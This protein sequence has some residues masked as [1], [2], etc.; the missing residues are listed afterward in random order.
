[1]RQKVFLFLFISI[2]ALAVSA[3]PAKRERHILTLADGT[4]VEA[5]SMGDELLHFYKTEDGRCL[6]RDSLGIAHFIGSDELQSRWKAKAERRQAARAARMKKAPGSKE[7]EEIRPMI[8]SKTGLVVLVEFPD[9]KFLFDE[10]EFNS[11]FNERGYSGGNNAGSVRDYYNDV[12][13]GLFDFTFDVIGPITMSQPLSYYGANNANGDDKGPGQMVIEALGMIDDEVDF[14]K[15]DWDEDGKVEQIFF[16]HA[17]YDEA[18]SG[19][20]TDI[21]SHA[22]TL[23][24]AKEYGDG[25]GPVTVDGVLA[26]RYATSSELRGREG[27]YL[28]GIGTACHEFAH[29]FGLPDFYDT[30]SGWNFGM[31]A[32]D[33]MDYGCYNGNGGTPCGFTSYE[34]MVCGWLKPIELTDALVVRNMPAITSEPVAYIL[35]N[36]GKEDE[37]YLLEN[38]QL[39]GWD[40]FL[41]GHGMLIL[42]VDYDREAWAMNAVNVERS[43]QRMTIIAADNML[44]SGTLSGDPWPGTGKKTELSST[45]IP[46]AMLYNPNAEGN[47]LMPHAISEISESEDGRISF[48]F[49]E[50]ALGIGGIENEELRMKNEESK[51]G[52]VYDLSGRRV[53]GEAKASLRPGIYIVNGKKMIMQ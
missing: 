4:K 8:G 43:H 40:G 39:E 51:D 50:E 12:S 53:S 15:Y 3:V 32:W 38:R 49:D 29:C 11:Y 28:A 41:Y 44:Y 19:T 17:G 1:M 47:K 7:A 30:M 45:S 16:I 42:H 36:S 46:A 35:R 24:E 20:S 26:D 10:K 13:Y 5:V 25:K 9:T 27:H 33:I 31:N 37:Y 21:W 14:T 2:Y 52:T 22:W 18:Q 34:R 48:I 6:Q 23:T